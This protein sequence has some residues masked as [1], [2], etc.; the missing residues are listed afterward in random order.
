MN[1]FKKLNVPLAHKLI[2]ECRDY[3]LRNPMIANRALPAT[4]YPI[5]PIDLNI[6]CPIIN[7]VFNTYELTCNFAA[8]YV[9][10]GNSDSTVHMDAYKHECRINLPILNCSNTCTVFYEGGIWRNFI[11]PDTNAP[12]FQ[13]VSGDLKFVDQVE[14]DMPTVVRVLVPHNVIMK[15]PVKPR[16]TLTLGFD[17]DPVFLLN[18]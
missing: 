13:Y 16:I 18:D 17:K 4:F 3:I 15:T 10:N 1:Y 9:M 8:A 14:I 7:E 11:N 6:K 2:N 12:S 5:D